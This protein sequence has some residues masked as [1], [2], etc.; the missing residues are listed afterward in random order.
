MKQHKQPQLRA[1]KRT[2]AVEV[3]AGMFAFARGSR[4]H[5]PSSERLP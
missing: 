3:R 2:L 5:E 1:K 4:G